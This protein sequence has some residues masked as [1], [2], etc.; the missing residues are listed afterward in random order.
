M[1][2]VTVLHAPRNTVVGLRTTERDGYEAVV[3][4]AFERGGQWKNIG[5]RYQMIREVALQQPTDT[6]VGAQFGVE[7]LEGRETVKLSGVTKGRGFQGV[8]RRHNFATGRETHGSGHFRQPGSVGMCAKPGRIM[9]GK[10]LP[11]QMG[12]GQM[13]LRDVK[14]FAID[15]AQDLIIVEG[16]VPGANKSLVFLRG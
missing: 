4:G 15:T 14:I 2:V 7:T 9:R 1:T 6:V 12:A 5:K 10:K 13:T 11:G 3:L 8:V 16:S